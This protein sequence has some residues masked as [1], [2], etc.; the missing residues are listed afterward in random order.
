LTGLAVAGAQMIALT[1]NSRAAN[2][3]DWPWLPVEAAMTPRLRSFSLSRHLR[4]SEAVERR[5]A[6]QRGGREVRA[7]LPR[8]VEH[9]GERRLRQLSHQWRG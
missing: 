9:V 7:D 5:V 4:A 3:T 1:P 2:A 8:R 6:S